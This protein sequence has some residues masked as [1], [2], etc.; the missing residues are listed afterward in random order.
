MMQAIM[1]SHK[2]DE[3]GNPTGG[4]SEGVGIVI[5]WQDGPLG[6]H[7]DGGVVDPLNGSCSKFEGCT[8]VPQNG[9]FVEGVIAAAI[10]RLKHYQASKFNCPENATAIQHLELA[11]AAL[12]S[13]TSRRETAK[14]EGTHGGN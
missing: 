12:E 4:T 14:V 7:A 5:N 1:E 10:G 8:R 9:A 2:T 11:L 6:R 13:R 3:A